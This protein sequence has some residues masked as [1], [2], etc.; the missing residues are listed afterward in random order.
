MKKILFIALVA[1]AGAANAQTL[2]YGGDADGRD[3]MQSQV[4]GSGTAKA[5]IYDDFT[6]TTTSLITGV[7]GNFVEAGATS[8]TGWYEIRSGMSAGNGGTVVSSNA[9]A[10]PVV[11]TA[12]SGANGT[13]N[14][15]T[16]HT[17][18]IAVAVTLAPG[19]YWL[20]I[21]LDRTAAGA[22][23]SFVATTGG[24]N[25]VGTPLHNGNSFVNDPTNSLSFYPTNGANYEGGGTW[26]VSYGV[27]GAAVPE[28]A[29]MAALG[30]GVAALLRR[31]KK[32]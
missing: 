31:R 13:L 11:Q 20:G 18:T 25:G 5:V 32:A 24:A 19:T 6:I 12:Y 15:L 17:Y 28:P 1:V 3:A 9:A 27:R 21:A 2:F 22:G 4:G 30:L 26:D 29:T 7:F 16:V 14:N 10:L 23:Q 8:T